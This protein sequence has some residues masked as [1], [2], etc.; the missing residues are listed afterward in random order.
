MKKSFI[1][2]L[3]MFVFLL[4]SVSAGDYQVTNCT[5]LE[6]IASHLTDDV[7]IMNDIDCEYKDFAE[8]TSTFEGNFYGQNHTI[9]NV[10]ITT[11][12]RGAM[13]KQVDNAYFSDVILDGWICKGQA[14]SYGA[15]FV[16]YILDGDGTSGMDQVAI[17]NSVW[18]SL[19]GGHHE[20]GILLGKID[21]VDGEDITNC[22]GVNNTIIGGGANIGGLIGQINYKGDVKY[23]YVANTTVNGTT[24]GG[25]LGDDYS[26]DGLITESFGYGN[27]INGTDVNQ[28]GR[29][30]DHQSNNYYDSNYGS[31][32]YA[33]G[34]SESGY[35]TNTTKDGYD[36][37]DT[38]NTGI[39]A[40]NEEGLPVFVWE[41]PPTHPPTVEF[42][43]PTPAN[44]SEI[45]TTVRVLA[46]V[47]D[48][49]DDFKNVT[50][51]LYNTT[52]IVSK[53]GVRGEGDRVFSR[54][55]SIFN[56]G[57]VGVLTSALDNSSTTVYDGGDAVAVSGYQYLGLGVY[58]GCILKENG[59]VSCVNSMA[60][61]S[62]SGTDVIGISVGRWHACMLKDSG[63][64]E[65]WLAN[66]S[67]QYNQSFNYTGGDAIAVS[68]G[69]YFT[70]FI[71]EGGDV[72]CFGD[73]GDGA[74]KNLTGVGAQAISTGDYHTCIINGSNHVTCYGKND[75]GQAHNY[76]QPVV[77]FGTG[78]KDTCVV[79][80]N[81]NIDCDGIDGY[82]YTGG[83]AIEVSIVGAGATFPSHYFMLSNATVFRPDDNFTFTEDYRKERVH[84]F[85]EL[86]KTTYY[87]NAT[88]CD[89]NGDCSASDTYVWI[90]NN[91]APVLGNP[92]INN[93]NPVVNSTLLCINGSFTDDD[94]DPEVVASRQW[95]WY[96]NDAN[97]STTTQTLSVS[98]NAVRG[99]E[100][101]CMQRAFD[102][103]EY[104]NYANSSAVTVLNTPPTIDPALP[105]VSEAVGSAWSVNANAT[106]PDGDTLVWTINLSLITIN[107]STGVFNDTPEAGHIGTYIVLV[108]VTDGN[109]SD[110]DIFIYSITDPTPPTYSD[111]SNNA[112][113]SRVGSSVM[114][115]VTFADDTNV[116]KYRFDTNDTGAWV[117]GSEVETNGT[118]VNV[119]YNYT[120]TATRGTTVCGRF[121]FNDTSQ[122]TNLTDESC[123]TVA[124]SL[125][126]LG[127]PTI[128]N[129]DPDIMD[130]LNCTNGSIADADGDAENAT[131]REWK[132]FIND[133]DSGITTQTMWVIGNLSAGDTVICSERTTDGYNYSNYA[134]STEVTLT[135]DAMLLISAWNNVTNESISTFTIYTDDERE[136]ST[137]T[138]FTYI[139]AIIGENLTLQIS[140]EDMTDENAT[141]QPSLN[142]TNYTFYMF[143][144]NSISINLYLETGAP[145]TQN[146]NV[147][148]TQ[149]AV[150]LYY[151]STNESLYV[152]NLSV[153]DWSLEFSKTGYIVPRTYEITVAN[154]SH[155]TLDV[156][157][158][159]ST[160]ETTFTIT[161][162]ATGD[163][164]DNV[165]STMYRT[166]NG[167]WTTVESH[168][169]DVAGHVT[170]TYTPLI[171][172][173][174][175]L[176]RT[177]YTAKIFTLTPV[178]YDSYDIEMTRST[179]P[180]NYSQDFD[181]L[182]IIFAPSQFYN[183]IEQTFEWLISS[184]S[185]LLINYG[186]TITTPG[187]GAN[188][189]NG[190]NA[191]GEQLDMDITPSASTVFDTVRVDY[192]YTTT[193]SGFRNFTTFLPIIFVNGSVGGEDVGN[194][195]F[196]QNKDRTYGLGIF[197]RMLICTIIVLFVA[198]IGT[199][200]GQPIPGA[201]LALF[202]FGY[203]SFIG[204][205]PLWTI[206]PSLLI[207]FLFVVWK[208]GGF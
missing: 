144:L 57:S 185:G 129:S 70:C 103:Y 140:A 148:F 46:N 49:G 43:D 24:A 171:D 181:G 121:K 133:A 53:S 95:K 164:I 63:N 31:D 182:S 112:S 71:V 128:N 68:C 67:N 162:S 78:Y 37:M 72:K 66:E 106:D 135:Y 190:T 142:F 86:P 183:G 172:Y 188:S 124:N 102:G 73:N 166:I 150:V 4:Y 83:D 77:S 202:V 97:I 13:F 90:T 76:S 1:I 110:T 10:N 200:V 9:S 12:Y 139:P 30:L 156:Y 122:N 207:G 20:A 21:T 101:I 88:S 58:N 193:L 19:S 109:D 119:L 80:P 169:S 146:I 65:C 120:L 3:C 16:G 35:F 34:I 55:Y 161:D 153:G 197:E 179:L 64:I 22:Y 151:V 178:L 196:M 131:A 59:S 137:T 117:N 79:Y 157:L 36:P 85:Y 143:G 126:V 136:F 92:T 141:I 81:G 205:V 7:Y 28:F 52:S 39:W 152:S 84:S 105:D 180:V 23:V 69:A 41:L 89:F 93:S 187:Y 45:G 32:S 11:A 114:W 184:P 17:K 8:I 100:I 158:S 118:P 87:F 99:D 44:G 208:S 168:Y 127:A 98:G 206:L 170:F 201:V 108:N 38:W 51:F 107:T 56:N 26:Y 160:Y 54:G 132:W 147:S 96:V 40:L 195:T 50:Y 5:D 145:V 159:N 14:N 134:N 163:A 74:A 138:N 104:S 174:F 62:Y 173:R 199:L 27:I 75:E 165:L 125:P 198:G 191:L 111:L 48:T 2:G 177:N 94:G 33:T 155:Q 123:L 60:G 15:C 130:V 194:N 149:D 25:V 91:T 82:D 29:S 18:I 61:Y 42:I 192:W 113:N 47:T 189:T 167:T 176:S 204:F 116:D 186:Y 154:N 175:Y 6:G 203:M 115:N